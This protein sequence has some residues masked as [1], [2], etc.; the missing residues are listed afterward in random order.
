MNTQSSQETGV[1][2]L[3]PFIKSVLFG[4]LAFKCHQLDV[5]GNQLAGMGAIIF[6]LVAAIAGFQSL[7]RWTRKRELQRLEKAAEQNTETSGTAR[8]ATK[9]DARKA[10]MHRKG[11]DS[12]FLGQLDGKDLYYPGE[13]HGLTI[14]PPG[15]GK[16]TSLVIPNMLEIDSSVVCM[17]LKLEIAVLTAKFRREVL[18]HEIMVLNPMRDQMEQELGVDMGDCGFNPMDFIDDGPM[19]R[20]DAELLATK[21]LPEKPSMSGS[22]GYFN[23]FGREIDVVFTM[24]LISHLK[25]E[26]VNL[27]ELR[28]LLF[29]SSDGFASILMEMSESDAWG[30]AVREY[31][32]K[33]MGTSAAELSGGLSMAQKAL[34]FYAHGPLAEHVCREGGLDPRT[35][36]K[37]RQTVYVCMPTDRLEA[38]KEHLSMVMSLMIDLAARDRSSD[39]R[40]LFLLDEFGNVELPEVV[41]SMAIYRAQKIQFWYVI[42]QISQ[43]TEKYGPEGCRSILGMCEVI[44]GFGVWEQ[45]TVELLSK[46]LG[47]ESV[48]SYSQ[49]LHPEM[50]DSKF[51]YNYAASDQGAP[52]MRP[53]EIRRMPEDQQ[54]IFYKNL[55]P[56]LATKV[57]YYTRRR[58]RRRAEPNPYVKKGGRS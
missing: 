50:N 1:S 56:I 22:D 25:R 28:R 37:K 7:D 33:L 8:W 29:V 38:N 57:P 32:S 5:E 54:L 18:G 52:L 35:L 23:D 39:N 43:L 16:T 58:W 20:E 41:R 27:P 30:G 11:R 3:F 15:A 45:D 19:V 40:C 51:G 4:W 46:M 31:A 48:R 53:D 10:G 47:D 17:D 2:P 12:F 49:T 34:R 14:A 6:G 21:L 55:P 9:R 26:H 44:N 36:K 42:Q 24:Y 13:T